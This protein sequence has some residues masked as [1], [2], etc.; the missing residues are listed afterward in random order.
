M[1]GTNCPTDG[2]YKMEEGKVPYKI[3]EI[4]IS[5]KNGKEKTTLIKK[6][7]PV[8]EPKSSYQS[9]PV[10]KKKTKSVFLN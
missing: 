8:P 10:P 6:F 4:F 9:S 7:V 5:D 1:L 2:C 3:V